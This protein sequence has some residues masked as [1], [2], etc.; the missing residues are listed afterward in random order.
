[1]VLLVGTVSSQEVVR[2]VS[3]QAMEEF[4]A[5][6]EVNY[7]ECELDHNNR[8]DVNKVFTT[9]VDNIVDSVLSGGQNFESEFFFFERGGRLHLCG[10]LDFCNHK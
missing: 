7:F 8:S 6:Q 3:R 2:E 4:A 1:M 10:L 5:A 9:L